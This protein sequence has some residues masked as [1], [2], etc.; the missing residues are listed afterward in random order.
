MAEGSAKKRKKGKVISRWFAKNFS[1]KAFFVGLSAVMLFAVGMVYLFEPY[2]FRY[3]YRRIEKMIVRNPQNSS[4]SFPKE[5][6]VGIDISYYQEDIEWDSV[7]FRVHPLTKTL[8]KSPDAPIRNIDFVVAKATE[9][10]TI[11]D[12]KYMRNK[13][14]AERRGILFGAYHFFSENSDPIAQAENFLKTA[15]LKNGNLVPVLDVE[16][17][18]RFSRGE[19][20]EN[21]LKWLQHVENHLGKKPMIYTYAKFHDEVFCTEEFEDYHFWIAHY[22]VDKP[23]NDCV[24]WQFTEEGVVYG[25]KGYVDIDVYLGS[26][27]RFHDYILDF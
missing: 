26:V 4:I 5:K 19:L 2:A 20:R 13:E 11:R 1:W 22:G 8:T 21:V 16:V 12:P 9:G 15:Q 6:I 7:C 25:I 18:D 3:A 27:D 23:I 24:F 10:V 14:G 17:R